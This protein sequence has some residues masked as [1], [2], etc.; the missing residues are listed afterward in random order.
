MI[1]Q[2]FLIVIFSKYGHTHPC[3]V[4]SYEIHC[5]NIEKSCDGTF[6]E[7]KWF[8]PKDYLPGLQIYEEYAID[9]DVTGFEWS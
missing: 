2:L 4:Q 3:L 6:P 7:T 8:M 1:H 9:I 5:R